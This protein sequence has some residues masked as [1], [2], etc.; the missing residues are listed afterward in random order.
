[1]KKILLSII[2][3]IALIILSVCGFALSRPAFEYATL[4]QCEDLIKDNLKSPSSYKL[5]KANVFPNPNINIDKDIQ[6]YIE[7]LPDYAKTLI[8]ENELTPQTTTVLIDYEAMNTLGVSLKNKAFCKYAYTLD[9]QKNINEYNIKLLSYMIGNDYI[10]N[11]FL[12]KKSDYPDLNIL[13]FP[14]ERLQYG[15]I[16]QLKSLKYI[17]SDTKV[18]TN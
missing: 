2:G 3:I 6:P 12:T 18:N 17:L 1:M 11:P 4:S 14:T 7:A 15:F 8:T 5:L 10:F 13:I 16:S 9:Q